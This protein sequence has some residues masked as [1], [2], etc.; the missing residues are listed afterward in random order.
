M[1]QEQSW[2]EKLEAFIKDLFP[3]GLTDEEADEVTDIVWH[4]TK[5]ALNQTFPCST[6]DQTFPISLYMEHRH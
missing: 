3:E 5:H 4:H 6:C 1:E 2:Q